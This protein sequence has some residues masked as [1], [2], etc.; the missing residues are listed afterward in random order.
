MSLLLYNPLW[1]AVMVETDKRIDMDQINLESLAKMQ[2][3][4]LLASG[5]FYGAASQIIIKPNSNDADNVEN[6]DRKE[7]YLDLAED[8]EE[9]LQQADSVT[10]DMDRVRISQIVLRMYHAVARVSNAC[11][12]GLLVNQLR[13]N[14]DEA[15]VQIYSRLSQQLDDARPDYYSGS[16]NMDR[17]ERSRPR[18]VALWSRRRERTIQQK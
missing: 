15:V 17:H 10:S 5:L 7:F 14:Q 6:Y 16:F 11:H 13:W 2:K 3:A 1:E 8:C 12:N 4:L 9:A 18:M